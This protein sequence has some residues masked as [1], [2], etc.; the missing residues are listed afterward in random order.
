MDYDRLSRPG[1]YPS[2]KIAVEY[3]IALC[4]AI[5]SAPVV[6]LAALLVKL[7]SEGPAFYTQTRVGRNGRHYKLYKHRSMRHNCERV[8][9][10]CWSQ[11]GDQRVTRL[12]RFLRRTHIDE[13]PQ[14]LNVLRGE[15]S[16]VGPRP[17][18]PEFIPKL[19]DALPLYRTRLLVR[20]GLTGLAQVQLPADTDIESVRRKLAYDLYY[21]ENR[22]PRL[23]FQLLLATVLYLLRVPYPL[24]AKFVLLPTDGQIARAYLRSSQA[25]SSEIPFDTLLAER[26]RGTT[27][28]RDG[29]PLSFHEINPTVLAS[30]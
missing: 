17:E 7:T 22:S 1:Y 5:L 19:E 6:V 8:S 12:G 26:P 14:L 27:E 18:R 2:A 29:H 16:L 24:V 10:P 21:I 15:M 28:R 9:G 11:A 3:V 13:L 4:L 25:L 23:D 20:P 30:S